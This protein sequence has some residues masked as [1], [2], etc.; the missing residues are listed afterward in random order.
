MR[1]RL[2]LALSVLLAMAC[3]PSPS[4]PAAPARESTGQVPATASAD[5]DRLL[6]AAKQEGSVTVFGPLGTQARAA[7]TAPFEE[8]YGIRV[9]YVAEAGP[10]ITPKVALE[11]SAGQYNYDIYIG[12]TTTGLTGL[13][14]LNVFEPMEPG[15]VL[16]EVTDASLWR[17]G[18][19]EFGDDQRQIV[20]MTPFQRGILF[21]NPSLVRAEELTSHKDLLDPKWK[22]RLVVDDPR[23][24]GSGQ[25]TFTFY[26]LHPELGPDFIRALAQQEPV[27]LRE[28]QQEVDAL[29]QGRF[30]ILIGTDDNIAGTRINQGVPIAIVDPRQLR[31]RTDISPASGAMAMFNRAPHPSAAKVYTNWLLSKEGQTTF[32]RSMGYVSNRLDVPTDHVP[33]WRVPLPDSVK[34]Y[35]MD[36]FKVR[37]PALALFEE[38][39]GSGR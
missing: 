31:E 22:G 35:T 7:L 18:A 36:A 17:G 12:G 20:V 29:G 19:L 24:A 32:V 11:R 14:P 21:I 1:C 5:W 26:Y 25:A 6:D 30:A 2:L 28:Y 27:V 33:E 38:V 9:E 16:P 13:I 10:N 15:L 34:T 4:A 39:F 23:K 37:E 3:S 8:K